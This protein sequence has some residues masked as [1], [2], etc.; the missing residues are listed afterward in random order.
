MTGRLADRF[1]GNATSVAD[2]ARSDTQLQPTCHG[3]RKKTSSARRPALLAIS[4]KQVRK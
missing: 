1:D 3:Q 2:K 4:K